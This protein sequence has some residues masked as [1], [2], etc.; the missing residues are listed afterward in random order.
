MSQVNRDAL[1]AIVDEVGIYTTLTM[2]VK[3]MEEKSETEKTYDRRRLALS[4]AKNIERA[5][6]IG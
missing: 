3:I 6:D 5:R 2:L 1:R 4:I